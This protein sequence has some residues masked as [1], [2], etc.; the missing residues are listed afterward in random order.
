ML[1]GTVICQSKSPPS[2]CHCAANESVRRAEA[3]LHERQIADRVRPHHDVLEAGVGIVGRD[4]AEVL[5]EPDHEVADEHHVVV[6][7]SSTGSAVLP[8]Q[9]SQIVVAPCEIM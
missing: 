7:S 1:G 4:A 5:V 6:R 9:S 2:F 3:G 8:F